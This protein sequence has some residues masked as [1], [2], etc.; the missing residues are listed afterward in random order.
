MDLGVF[1]YDTKSTFLEYNH[2]KG[3]LIDL[4]PKLSDGALFLKEN[5][6]STVSDDSDQV[7]LNSITVLL[8]EKIGKNDPQLHLLQKPVDQKHQAFF[9]SLRNRQRVLEVALSL[10]HYRHQISLV[11]LGLLVAL[12]IVEQIARK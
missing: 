7:V 4:H 9:F 11:F 10:H 8:L 12:E 2:W 3:F 6:A 5:I 1:L